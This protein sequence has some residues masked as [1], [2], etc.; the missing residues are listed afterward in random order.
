MDGVL[1]EDLLKWSSVR[2]SGIEANLNPQTVA[3]KEIA[4]N[5]VAARLVIET[6]HTINLLAALS[7]AGAN[8]PVDTNAPAITNATKTATVAKNPGV[9]ATNA[10]APAA[11][12]LISIGSIVI[13]NAAASF[14][15][16]SLTPSV[17]LAVLEAGGTI[18]GLSSSQLQHANVDL[19]AKVD[20]IGPVAIS[21][22]I[23]PFSGTET[24]D[25]KITVKD[26]DLTPTSPYS[27]KFAGYRIA[28][29][30]LNL[31]LAYDVIGR[32]LKSKN[33]I[34]LD[35]FTFG[36]KVESPD[37]THLPVRLAIAI[38]K[39]RNGQILL[40]V[41]IEG[42]F[43]DPQFRIGKVVVHTLLNILEK[44]ATSPFSLLGAAFGGGGEEL[45]YQDFAPG[46]VVLLPANEQKLDSLAKGLYERPG[47]Q[48][49]IAGS[50]DPEADRD[51]M[52]HAS[53]DK[54]I[55]TRQW[56]S[57]R[58]SERAA[59]TPSQITLT[60]EERAAWVKKL[61]GE[62]M[63]KGVINAAFIAAN[64]NLAAI[65]AHIKSA[66]AEN[67]K[68]ATILM[69]GLPAT[70]PQPAQAATATQPA[71]PVVSA[72]PKELLLM[73]TI[74]VTDNDF[75]ELAADR[76]KA[77]RAYLLQTGKVEAERLFLT[78]NRTGGVR[79]DG[80]RAYLQFR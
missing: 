8:A 54:Q 45:S 39:D 41:P 7:P 11:L 48:L 64:T 66:S 3:I 26:V 60:P 62:A 57:L 78:E 23:N 31:D 79:P 69:E 24:N 51:G 28:Q 38:L 35:R 22:I 43:D 16:R 1:G 52:R 65:A 17:N 76:A 56:Q 72:D 15:D 70:T 47:L 34:T 18:A 42:S 77:V 53:L 58:K 14:T 20:G 40:D 25:L 55:R 50:I 75:Q 37:A 4:L 29:G 32:K 63:G 30:K 46:S 21:G 44:V 68:G 5:N 6:N 27:G 12:P 33:V 67:E 9:P 2:V 59:T 80:S 71:K 61:Y 19:S 13:S 73:A 49:E 10:P 74:P 36:E